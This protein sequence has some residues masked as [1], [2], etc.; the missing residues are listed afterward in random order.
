M[1]EIL[2]NR[3]PVTASEYDEL[4]EKNEFSDFKDYI[5][6]YCRHFVTLDHDNITI[7]LTRDFKTYDTF[8]IIE[9]SKH[10]P[11]IDSEIT[12][13]YKITD[14]KHIQALVSYLDSHL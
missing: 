8:R 13:D 1:T 4:C 9:W 2:F 14:Y 10:K 6:T 3:Y 7:I 5:Y 11:I 12:T